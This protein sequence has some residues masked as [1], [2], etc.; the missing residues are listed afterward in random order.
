MSIVLLLNPYVKLDFQ[1]KY[2]NVLSF[3][4]K[5]ARVMPVVRRVD[6]AIHSIVVVATVL[7][8]LEKL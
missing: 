6:S 5:L 2:L 1:D 3:I 8:M 4:L 7:K